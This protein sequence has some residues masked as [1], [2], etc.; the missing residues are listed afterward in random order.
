M[1]GKGSKER[2][3]GAG[4]VVTKLSLRNVEMTFEFNPL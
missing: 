2:V 1:G 3:R 4:A